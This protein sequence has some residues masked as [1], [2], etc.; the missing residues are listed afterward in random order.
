MTLTRAAALGL[1][2][3]AGYAAVLVAVP[4]HASAAT[5]YRYW[6]FYLGKGTSWQYSPR[7]P[8]TEYPVDGDVQGW[9]FAVQADAADGLLPGAAPDFAKLCESSPPKAGELRVGVVIDFGLATDAPAHERPPAGVVPG[10][11]YVPDGET[12]MDALQAAAAIRIGTGSDTGLVCGIDGYPKTECAVAVAAHGAAPAT[13]PPT[14]TPAAASP[15]GTPSTHPPTLQATALSPAAA[16]TSAPETA[17][18]ADTAAARS[19]S[20][21]APPTVAAESS[22][23][24]QPA[25]TSALSFAALRSSTRHGHSVPAVTIGGIALIVILGAGAVWHTRARGR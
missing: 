20:L 6:A 7:G 17:V 21:P 4:G 14:P 13:A 24:A 3:L 8:A 25:A 19:A 11:V 1:A 5:G 22:V 10:C 15:R 12:D 18:A 9:R 2:A 23:P 16:P